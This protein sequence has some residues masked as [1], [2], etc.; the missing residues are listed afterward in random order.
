MCHTYHATPCSPAHLLTP[1]PCPCPAQLPIAINAVGIYANLPV[2][3]N[4]SSSANTSTGTNTSPLRLNACTLARI[5]S[6][7]ISSW[8]EPAI[9]ELNPG[10]R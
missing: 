9:K 5:F 7:Q 6:G 10:V 8:D 4:T 2:R 1:L 3:A